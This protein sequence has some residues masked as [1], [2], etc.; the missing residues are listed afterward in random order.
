MVVSF[1]VVTSEVGVGAAPHDVAASLRF[2]TE[3][4]GCLG[5]VDA[6]C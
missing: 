3:G 4:A 2:L 1:Q 6:G 5:V